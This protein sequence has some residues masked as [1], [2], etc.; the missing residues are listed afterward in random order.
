[1][2]SCRSTAPSAT[3]SPS[4]RAC[5]PTAISPTTW[6]SR[7]TSCTV[8]NSVGTDRPAAEQC[9]HDDAM[10]GRVFPQAALKWRYPWVQRDARRQRARSSRS[11]P[12]IAAPTAATRRAFP[13]RTARASSS[14]RRACSCPTACPATT[15]SIAASASITALHGEL[16]Q[17]FRRQ[18]GRRSSARAI[19]SSA[20]AFPAGLGPRRPA[21]RRRRARRRS[22][23]S[24]FST[25]S[26]ASASTRRFRD[27]PPGGRHRSA[28]PRA[29][30]RAS[31]Y[32]SIAPIPGVTSPIPTGD[33]IGATHRRRAHALLV[34]GAQR[35]ALHRQWRRDDQFRRRRHLSRR[36]LRRGHL[37]RRSRASASATCVPACR[38]SDLRLQEP[39]R[40]RRDASCPRA[41]HDPARAR[42]LWW[43]RRVSRHVCARVVRP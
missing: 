36:L 10:A 4:P 43:R 6:R 42:V 20:T 39:G 29:C 35:H 13:T 9:R 27:A 26:I 8:T 40:G 17:P 16:Q 38:C 23:P 18:R 34:G 28:G 5:A 30:A 37:G 15:A 33:Q 21:L 14:T 31:S 19:A 3:A 24:P 2:A 22:R 7:P 25:S 41:G 12:L 11:P 32:I 1:M